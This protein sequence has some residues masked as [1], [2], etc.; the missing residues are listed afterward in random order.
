MTPPNSIHN[1]GILFLALTVFFCLKVVAIM[2]F[3]PPEET[4]FQLDSQ[5]GPYTESLITTGVY[6]DASGP[7]IKKASRMPVLPLCL[8]WLGRISKKSRDAAV[9]KCLVLTL[10]SALFLVWFEKVH[11][12]MFPRS[13]AAWCILL[14][15]ALSPEVA[16]IAAMITPEESIVLELL[17]MWTLA[18]L[19]GLVALARGCRNHGTPLIA[20]CQALGSGLYLLKSSM[21]L[22]FLTSLSLGI[23]WTV[24]HRNIKTVLFLVIPLMPILA[25]GLHTRLATGRFSIATSW[26]GENAF[27]GLNSEAYELYPDVSLDQ[28]FSNQRAHLRNGAAVDIQAPVPVFFKDEWAWNDY[29]RDRSIA[30]LKAEPRLAF[31]FLCKKTENFYFSIE[32][33]PYAVFL[34]A[35]GPRGDE[36]QRFYVGSWLIYGRLM[37]VCMVAFMLVLWAQG[38]SC[39]RTLVAGVLAANAAYSA[40]Y[41]AIFNYERHIVVYLVLVAVC[42]FMLLSLSLDPAGSE[43]RK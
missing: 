13:G 30:W 28:V 31:K 11:R 16:R 19:M 43:E 3:I 15:L 33:T 17:F 9:V 12:T 27:R 22:V 4:V 21:F 2:E 35:R 14:P 8:S 6:A 38:G 1:P 42:V 10:L 29:F 18:F 5:F 20:L 32:E 39:Q 25:W 7:F 24:R 26:D 34:D 40:P 23:L 36:A 41:L 37:Q